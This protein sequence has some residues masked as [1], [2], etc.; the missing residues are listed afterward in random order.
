MAGG[1]ADRPAEAPQ[2]PLPLRGALA[3]L[4]AAADEYFGVGVGGGEVTLGA[5]MSVGADAG[6][7]Q[8]VQAQGAGERTG[9]GAGAGGPETGVE[10]V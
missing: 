1:G 4:L 10:S 2:P 9:T 5:G 8:V 7:K 3:E 6:N